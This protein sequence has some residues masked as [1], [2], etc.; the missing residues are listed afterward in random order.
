MGCVDCPLP[1]LHTVSAMG[2]KLCFYNKSRDGRLAH[3]I[4][5]DPEFVVDIAPRERWN[6]DVLEEEGVQKLQ[7]IVEEIKGGCATL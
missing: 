3:R 4:P 6:Y 2:T 7:A 5:S 1:N